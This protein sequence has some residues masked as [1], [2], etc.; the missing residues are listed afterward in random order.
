MIKTKTKSDCGKQ[1]GKEKLRNVYTDSMV[2]TIIKMFPKKIAHK[3]LSIVDTHKNLPVSLT[4][5]FHNSMFLKY[6]H[7]K[8]VI[9]F[10]ICPF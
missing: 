10:F 8:Y 9:F 1:N 2:V 6:W 4:Q 3:N 5:Q 7:T